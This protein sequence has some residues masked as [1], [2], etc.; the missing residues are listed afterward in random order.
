MIQN[1]VKPPIIAII[2]P[3]ASGKSAIG[4]RLA[5]KFKGAVISA[6]SQQLY[7]Q[8]SIGTNQ[9][10]GQWQKIGTGKKLY[11]VD[12]IPHFFINIL[13][14]NKQFSAAQFQAQ[15]NQL[16]QNLSTDRI[17]PIMV[18]GTGLYVSAIVQDYKFPNSKPNLVLRAKL[19]KLSTAA[20]QQK[21]KKL[22]K[23]TW[24]VIDK[25]NRR[26]LV[27]ALE[28]VLT[29]RQS[30]SASQQK[31][32]RSN[33]LLIG[34]NVNKK[35]LRQT[36]VKRTNKMFRLGLIKEVEYLRKKYPHSPLLQSIGYREV[37]NYLTGKI[38]LAETKEQIINHTWQYARRQT[39]WF[40]K[41]PNIN[42]VNKPAQ[43]EKLVRK[44]LV[45][46]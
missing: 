33:T 19:N 36:I 44:F 16:C 37:V 14:P 24:L 20:L 28:F 18:G 39:T 15:T 46:Y 31:N 27:R 32:T 38:N 1:S 17:L 5:K 13:S 34:I 42:W 7:R 2:G 12:G 22:D 45:K 11:I 43:A 3:T 26:R 23:A 10:A 21:L 6:D 9:P 30:F 41:I 25:T 4:L 29:T 8:A 40:K 35:N